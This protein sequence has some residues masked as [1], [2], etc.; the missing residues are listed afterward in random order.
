MRD[1]VTEDLAVRYVLGE[2]SSDEAA[3]FEADLARDGELRTFLK[4]LEETYASFALAVP[5]G[6]PPAFLPDRITHPVATRRTPR[7][8]FTFIPWA[9]AA[10]LAFAAI[11]LFLDRTQ[12]KNQLASVT[13]R[14]KRLEEELTD[15]QKRNALADNEIAQLRKKNLLSQLTIA[16]LQAQVGQFAR[17]G[18]VAVWD[19]AQ[20]S[21]IM[22]FSDLPAA[23]PG[24]TYQLWII[25]PK[26]TQP[27]SAGLI[28]VANTGRVRVDLKPAKPIGS[29]AKFAVSIEQAGGSETPKGQIVLL[30]Q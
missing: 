11:I 29:A 19:S 10:A 2:L 25:D 15:L 27:V 6:T 26:Q 14:N 8:F 16:S 7:S 22:Q 23:Q 21:G 20:N 4:E 30:G 28:P 24:K 9:L 5:P 3:R 1:D 17:T 12:I 13:D 18:A